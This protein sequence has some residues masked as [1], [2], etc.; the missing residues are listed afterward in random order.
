MNI[1]MTR[2][3]L[4]V[5]ASLSL[6]ACRGRNAPSLEIFGAYFPD[7]LLYGMFGVF[8]ALF[9]RVLIIKMRLHL[10]IPYQFFLCTALGM[11][12]AALFWL[13]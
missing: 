4:V 1:P 9:I 2:I 5:L 13:F 8:L 12:L 3:T 7:W 6:A 11:S 10:V